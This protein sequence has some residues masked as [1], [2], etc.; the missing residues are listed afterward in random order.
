MLLVPQ[1]CCGC[2]E[3]VLD[4]FG[5]Y[6]PFLLFES[7]IMKDVLFVLGGESLLLMV[8]SAF[9]VVVLPVV[10]CTTMLRIHLVSGSGYFRIFLPLYRV[11]LLHSTIT[12]SHIFRGMQ[13]NVFP[14]LP[15]Y[16][17]IVFFLSSVFRFCSLS[18]Y[19]LGA[20]V[21]VL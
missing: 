18:M 12:T 11:P 21:R 9:F 17:S 15:F 5:F 13:D 14:L 7:I 19:L 2:F 3:C 8:P 20:G 10:S 16:F 6:F 1:N 4:V